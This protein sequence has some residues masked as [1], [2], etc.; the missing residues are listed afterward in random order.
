MGID[1][2]WVQHY[3]RRINLTHDAVHSQIGTESS[4][5]GKS[6]LPLKDGATGWR[7]PTTFQMGII[8][9]FW[10]SRVLPKLERERERE[11]S[12]KLNMLIVAIPVNLGGI[13]PAGLVDS[14]RLAQKT[15]RP[16]VGRV[17]EDFD[18]MYHAGGGGLCV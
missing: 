11:R 13:R 10:E 4:V 2:V 9:G 15:D 7:Y 17:A 18:G 8:L 16:E 5:G 14:E 6:H 3:S 12:A 1:G